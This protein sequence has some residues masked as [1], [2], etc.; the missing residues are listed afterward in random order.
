MYVIYF[1]HYFSGRYLPNTMNNLC[2]CQKGLEF[3]YEDREHLGTYIMVIMSHNMV[4]ME[5]EILF[6]NKKRFKK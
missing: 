1:C 5:Q 3:S 4:N 2:I 6:C